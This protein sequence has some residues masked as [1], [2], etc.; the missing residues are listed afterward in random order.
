VAYAIAGTVLKDLSSEPLGQ[1]FN[2]PVYL[3]GHLADQS[4]NRVSDA[5]CA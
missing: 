4:R 1:G 3:R 5:L 2:G